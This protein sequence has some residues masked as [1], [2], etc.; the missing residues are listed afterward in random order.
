MKNL[1]KI[2]QNMTK[3]QVENFFNECEIEATKYEVTV[4]YY[5]QEF[6]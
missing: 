6:L 3:E 2:I 4:D 5:M 1:E